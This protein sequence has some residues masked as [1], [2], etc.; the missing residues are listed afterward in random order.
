MKGTWVGLP[1][2]EQIT[3]C[4]TFVRPLPPSDVRRAARHSGQRL[5]SFCSPRVW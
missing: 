2:L 1:Q 4:M 5:G 3:S